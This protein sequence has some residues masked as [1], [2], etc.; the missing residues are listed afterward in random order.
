MAV[1]S[2]PGEGRRQG[3]RRARWIA[4]GTAVGAAAAVTGTVAAANAAPSDARSNSS[5]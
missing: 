4:A 1:P 5:T 3:L 2:T